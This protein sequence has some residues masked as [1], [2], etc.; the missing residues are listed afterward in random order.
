MDRCGESGR[1][2][3]CLASAIWLDLR[4]QR[5]APQAGHPSVLNEVRSRLA[6]CRVTRLA[7]APPRH[8][9]AVAWIPAC[10]AMMFALLARCSKG[11]NCR[12]VAGKARIGGATI[13]QWANGM[14]ISGEP[15]FTDIDSDVDSPQ[16]A[17]F[18]R[19]LA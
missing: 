18:G 8:C 11:G 13:G 7:S 17:L 15:R 3:V 1:S 6:T 4:S 2:T 10:A 5:H 12:Y 19:D 9:G 16:S 14:K